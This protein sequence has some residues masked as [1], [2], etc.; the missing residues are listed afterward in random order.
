MNNK[1]KKCLD[2]KENGNQQSYRQCRKQAVNLAKANN[3]VTRFTSM[4][5]EAKE[6]YQLFDF[7]N[8][9]DC[10]DEEECQHAMDYASN[11][12]QCTKSAIVSDKRNNRETV[13]TNKY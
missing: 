7:E 10:G 13:S 11:D 2:F 12:L 8:E 4:I 6:A 9:H 1:I 3:F 5:I